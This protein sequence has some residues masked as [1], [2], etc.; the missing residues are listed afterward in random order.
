[1][2]CVCDGVCLYVQ[3]CVRT[4]SQPGQGGALLFGYL[5]PASTGHTVNLVVLPPDFPRL[6]SLMIE[7]TKARVS[8]GGGKLRPLLLAPV[9]GWG[10]VLH[11]GAPWGSP[12]AVDQ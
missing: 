7:L 12:G 8:G 9:H 1:M 2:V 4:G 10:F 6:A 11:P 3:W 5:K